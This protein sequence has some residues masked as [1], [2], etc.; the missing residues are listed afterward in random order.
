MICAVCTK[1][2]LMKEVHSHWYDHLD[3]QPFCKEC[4]WRAMKS[5]K[6]MKSFIKESPWIDIR[7]I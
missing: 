7:K 5:G 1:C 2:N 6:D 4:S 3:K